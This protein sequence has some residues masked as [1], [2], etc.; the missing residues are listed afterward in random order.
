MDWLYFSNVG[1]RNTNIC[2][3]TWSW[4]IVTGMPPF[5][6]MG[7]L[8]CVLFLVRQTNSKLLTLCNLFFSTIFYCMTLCLDLSILRKTDHILSFSAYIYHDPILCPAWIIRW[9]Y[10][11]GS[12]RLILRLPRYKMEESQVV[13]CAEALKSTHANHSYFHRNLE[14]YSDLHFSLKILCYMCWAVL[15][16]FY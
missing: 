9:F 5:Q 16:H 14:T 10:K 1:G 6:V 4:Y 11:C 7:K 2:W 12:S 8:C 3:W 13:N 15:A